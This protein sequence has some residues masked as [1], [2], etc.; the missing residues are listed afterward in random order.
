[1]RACAPP[2]GLCVPAPCERAV[3]D[4]V[5]ADA[6]RRRAARERR[7]WGTLPPS[8]IR[9]AWTS[10]RRWRSWIPRTMAS[11]RRTSTA[12]E[13]G[14]GSGLR[15]ACTASPMTTPVGDTALVETVGLRCCA[16]PQVLH[17]QLEP[18]G[19]P[20]RGTAHA[21]AAGNLDAPE[22]DL[23][24]HHRLRG[25][26]HLAVVLSCCPPVHALRRR[27]RRSGPNAFLPLCSSCRTERSTCTS[28]S[29]TSATGFVSASRRSSR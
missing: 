5:N 27:K 8:S 29:A 22:G 12:S 13:C 2:A 14:A 16:A 17:R 25:A 26:A 23:L 10:D 1:V 19:F 24:R 15:R 20:R 28:P 11:A 7:C 18:E 6:A 3:R 21:H 4:R 9:W